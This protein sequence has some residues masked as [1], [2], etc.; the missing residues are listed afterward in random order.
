MKLQVLVVVV[1]C[2]LLAINDGKQ[3]VTKIIKLNVGGTRYEA[4]SGLL[5]VQGSLLAELIQQADREDGALKDND[6][7]I[8]IDRE[9]APFQDI[10]SFLRQDQQLPS[11]LVSTPEVLLKE[12]TFYRLPSLVAQLKKR[13]PSAQGSTAQS[14]DFSAEDLYKMTV[15]AAS[16]QEEA[17]L[18]EYKE[19]LAAFLQGE[20]AGGLLVAT[21]FIPASMEIR[22]QQQQQYQN[23][24]RAQ[25][26]WPYGDRN[27]PVQ[28]VTSSATATSTSFNGKLNFLSEPFASLTPLLCDRAMT[29]VVERGFHID[30]NSIK[31][32]ISGGGSSYCQHCTFSFS[33]SHHL[34]FTSF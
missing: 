25:K 7:A 27:K 26:P 5:A 14:R 22:Q 12:A 6:G 23:Q 17:F 13:F 34:T 30:P 1:F 28:T 33:W 9:G 2:C 8:F 24:V 32:P 21:V 4:S 29:W 11:Q 18:Q 3:A 20:V 16:K 31:C 10:L 19:K 15:T